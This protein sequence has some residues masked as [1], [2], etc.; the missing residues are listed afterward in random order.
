MI[1]HPDLLLGQI[2]QHHDDL[3]AEARD[4]R[5]FKKL[6]RGPDDDGPTSRGR[7]PVTST[8]ARRA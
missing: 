3:R 4:Y 5:L 7:S 2:K 6:R 8:R 1:L